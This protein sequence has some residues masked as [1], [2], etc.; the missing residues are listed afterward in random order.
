MKPTD[1]FGWTWLS[2]IDFGFQLLALIPSRT[3][4]FFTDGRFEINPAYNQ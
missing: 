3:S 2:C 4:L 1:A